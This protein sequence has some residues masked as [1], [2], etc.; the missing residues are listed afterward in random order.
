[1]WENSET[2]IDHPIIDAWMEWIDSTKTKSNM[3]TQFKRLHLNR[4]I[5]LADHLTSGNLAHEKFNLCC[6]NENTVKQPDKPQSQFRLEKSR[7]ADYQQGV[8]KMGN[9]IG[10]MPVVFPDEWVFAR[11]ESDELGVSYIPMLR[12]IPMKGNDLEMRSA[13]HFFQIDEA[14]FKLL[15][16]PYCQEDKRYLGWFQLKPSADKFEQTYNLWRFIEEKAKSISIQV[17]IPQL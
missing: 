3:K 8:A 15:F 7:E 16:T 13:M 12:S 6:Y 9:A 17:T 5:L 4:L 2:H 10:E 11:M 1:M 14:D